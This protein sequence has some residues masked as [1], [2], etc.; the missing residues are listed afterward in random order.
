MNE[1]CSFIQQVCAASSTNIGGLAASDGRSMTATLEEF[2]SI[3]AAKFFTSRTDGIRIF[4]WIVCATWEWRC[5][6]R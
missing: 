5:D 4:L 3:N 2:N 1:L 6:R